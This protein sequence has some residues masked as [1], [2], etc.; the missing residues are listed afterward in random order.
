[1]D[2]KLAHLQMVQAVIAR[3]AS[4]SFLLKGWSVTLVGALFALAADKANIAF[5]Y[6]AYFPVVMFWALDGFFLGQERLFRRLYDVVRTSSPDRSDF[7]M[8][9]S[10]VRLVGP[11]WIDACFSTTLLLFYGTIFGS[12]VIIMLILIFHH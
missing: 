9:T 2:A 6:L 3:M 10:E 12:I 11:G 8:D 1:M 4:N 7:S 5:I